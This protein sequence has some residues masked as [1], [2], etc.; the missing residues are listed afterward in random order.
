MKQRGFLLLYSCTIC[1]LNSSVKFLLSRLVLVI[2]IFLLSLY[3]FYHD[4]IFLVLITVT[5]PDL[6]EDADEETVETD[7]VETED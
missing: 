3:L 5:H 1:C 4:L 7:E 2:I 6:E